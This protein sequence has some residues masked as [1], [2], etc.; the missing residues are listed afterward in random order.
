MNKLIAPIALD[1]ML[2][3][4]PLLLCPLNASLVETIGIILAIVSGI[5]VVTILASDRNSKSIE[6]II[7]DRSNRPKWW[8]VY[9][10]A[11]DIILIASWA[12]VGIYIVGIMHILV[13]IALVSKVPE[14]YNK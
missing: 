4:I 1:M 12:F 14:Y 8:N 13:K 9:D 6:E 5:A 11:T 2:I 10:F 3:L 7:A